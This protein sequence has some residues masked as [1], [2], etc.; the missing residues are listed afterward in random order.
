MRILVV[1]LIL[2][3]ALL[4]GAMYVQYR[5]L[6]SCT[7]ATDSLTQATLAAL[8]RDINAQA[9]GALTGALANDLIRPAAEPLI[10]SVVEN[11]MKYKSWFDC[12]GSLVKLD[13]LGGRDRAAED[14]IRRML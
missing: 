3:P 2:V 14:L 10:R 12:A 11:D 7:A 1:L 9:P 6:N 8:S 4:L 5:T 13:L